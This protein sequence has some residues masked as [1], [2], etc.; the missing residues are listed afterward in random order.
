[1]KFSKGTNVVLQS[2]SSI[3]PSILLP[4]G[5]NVIRVTDSSKSMYA[6]AV[7]QEQVDND[8]NIYDMPQFMSMLKMFEDYD[9]EVK[10][11]YAHISF[12][13]KSRMRYVYAHPSVVAAP[14]KDLK[15]PKHHIEFELSKDTME[16]ILKVSSSSGMQDLV[17]E[18]GSDNEN[19]LLKVTSFES[20]STNESSNEWSMEIPATVDPNLGPFCIVFYISSIAKMIR[21]NYNVKLSAMKIGSFE[22]VSPQTDVDA[23]YEITYV[24]AFSIDSSITNPDDE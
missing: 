23:E 5:S 20:G 9:I 2:M 7:V 15:F 22:A 16:A 11:E 18:P 12:P 13:N 14:D 24:V 3:N 10:E 4:S 6:R 17:I 8:M 19:I 1:M 21:R